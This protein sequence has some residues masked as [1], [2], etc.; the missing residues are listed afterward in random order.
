MDLMR[1]LAASHDTSNITLIGM[2]SWAEMT[3]LDTKSMMKLNVHFLSAEIP[4]PISPLGTWFTN[5]FHQSYFAEPDE[6][7]YRGFDVTFFFMNALM[8][9]GNDF[10][11]CIGN[12]QMN[13]IQTRYR[14]SKNSPHGYENR[15]WN[16]YKYNNFRLEILNRSN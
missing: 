16:I 3:N 10:N 8:R 1:I 12:L 2:P 5:K 4:D 7:A 13:T 15:F 14:F 6:L 11:N 9:F